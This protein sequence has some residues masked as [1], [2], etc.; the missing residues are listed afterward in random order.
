MQTDLSYFI[1]NKQQILELT[2]E[3]TSIDFLNWYQQ[4]GTHIKL[5]WGDNVY[6]IEHYV[7]EAEDFELQ[8]EVF[9]N[10][11]LKIQNLIY[12]LKQLQLKENPHSNAELV[13]K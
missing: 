13:F 1:V 6:S 2:D 7:V 3:Q 11:N 9:T 10:C 8:E 5:P 12:Q 4:Y